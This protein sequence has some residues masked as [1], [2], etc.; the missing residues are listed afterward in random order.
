[1]TQAPLVDEIGDWLLG[2]A[3]EDPDPLTLFDELCTRLRSIGVPVERTVLTWLILHPLFASEEVV[4]KQGEETK[5]TQYDHSVVGSPRW[6]ESPFAHVHLKGMIPFRRRLTGPDQ[7]LD[8]PVLH[9]LAAEGMTDYVITAAVFR[10]GEVAGALGGKTGMIASWATSRPNG[11][12]PSDLAA[13]ERLRRPLAVAV[14]ASLQRRILGNLATAYLGPTAGHGVLAGDIRLGDGAVIP[15]VLWFSDL[16]GST[17]LS[18]QMAAGDYLALLNLYYACTAE[19]VIE[20]GGEILTFIGDGVLAGFRIGAEGPAGAVARAESALNDALT[21]HKAALRDGTPGDA[22][23]H[24]GVGLALGDVMMGNIGVP[25]RLAFTGIG[26]AVNRAQRIEAATKRLGHA[27]LAEQAV[28]DAASRR[29]TSAGTIPLDGL[30]APAA[31][32]RLAEL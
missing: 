23:L 26:T 18:D 8:F 21:R 17:R 3:L 6:M 24:F 15:A 28:V 16:R 27:V 11:F 1:M 25:T 5:L 14:H 12:T 22:P 13:L 31:L 10:V 7:L 20:A 4:W 19:P 29:W 2:R 30:E 32:Y 9:D